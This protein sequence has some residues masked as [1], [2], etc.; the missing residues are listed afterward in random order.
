M[1]G[2]ELVLTDIVDRVYCVASLR[3]RLNTTQLIL[4]EYS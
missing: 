1:E 4:T 2:E 3:P